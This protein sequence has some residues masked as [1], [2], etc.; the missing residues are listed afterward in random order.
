MA[1]QKEDVSTVDAFEKTTKQQRWREEQK[2]RG[3]RQVNFWMTA[4]QE[5][6]VKKFIKGEV[7]L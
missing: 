5:A 6:A 7:E 4:E 2:K 1:K 3:L